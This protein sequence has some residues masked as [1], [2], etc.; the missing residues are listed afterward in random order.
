MGFSISPPP[1]PPVGSGKTSLL[2]VISGRAEGKVDGVV[3]YRHHQCTRDTMRQRA[4]YVLQA[5]RLLPTLTV[6]ETLTYMALMKLPGN[7]SHDE[8][9]R[10]VNF[11]GWIL[12]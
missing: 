8:I 4:S 9:D 5:D 3:S 10:K 12:R 11:T 1:P 6:R 2:D 7:V